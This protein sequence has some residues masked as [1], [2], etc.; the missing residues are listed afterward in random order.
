MTAAENELSGPVGLLPLRDYQSATIDALRADWAVGHRRLAAVLP[1]GGGKT[2]IFAHLIRR[3]AA[4]GGR[5]LVLAHRDELL[6]QAQQKIHDVAP[7]IRTGIIKGSRREMAGRDAVIA[8]VQ[9]LRRAESRAEL[10][11][12]MGRPWLIIVD[13]AHH[14]V[15]NTYMNIIRDLGGFAPDGEPGPLVAG[16]TATLTRADRV[17]LGDVWQKVSI[18]VDVVDLMRRRYLVKPRGKRIKIAGLDLRK[19]ARSGGDYQDRSLA[20]AMSAAL[21]PEAIARAY[22]EHAPDRQGIAFL[23]SVALAHEQ[24]EVL[25]AEGISALAVDGK[26]EM[27]ARKD[28]LAAFRRGDCQV[29]TNCG[30]FTEGTDLPMAEVAVLGRPTSSAGLYVQMAGRVLRPH[31]GKSDALLLDVVGVAGKHKLASMVDLGGG[32]RV[33]EL[34]EEERDELEDLADELGMDLLEMLERAESGPSLDDDRGAD[35]PLVAE[36]IEL[37]E[38]S[39][40]AWLR[41]YRGAWCLVAGGRVVALAPL[42]SGRFDVVCMPLSGP[43][44]EYVARD[45]DLS[46]AMSWGEQKIAE[47]EKSASFTTAKAASWRKGK[48]SEAQGKELTRL[49]VVLNPD[50]SKSEASDAISI[51][52][53][54]RRIDHL[55]MFAGVTR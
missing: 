32:E 6:E 24:A 54:S 1:T 18:R 36:E 40:Q 46:Y 19:V 14:A 25:C 35:G 4:A 34:T 52:K 43:G 12:R 45:I 5:A 15:A 17:A 26:T 47:I 3:V 49:G 30:V 29:L 53:A 48:M 44:G 9:S 55:A 41:S 10:L 50:W 16:F 51:C 7:G 27:D 8:S 20:E 22:K 37:F 28:A 2:V 33:D 13:E 23:P 38:A 11:R 42:E 31:P 39:H 21:A